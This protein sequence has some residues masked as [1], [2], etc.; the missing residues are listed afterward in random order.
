MI[1]APGRVDTVQ[2]TEKTDKGRALARPRKG[3]FS[4][5][6]AK[7]QTDDPLRGLGELGVD[8]LEQGLGIPTIGAELVQGEGQPAGGGL[9]VLADGKGGA[10]RGASGGVLSHRRP[11]DGDRLADG[12]AAQC[13]PQAERTAAQG[14]QETGGQSAR[15]GDPHG[16]SAQGQQSDT[17]AADGQQAGGKTANGQKT[18]GHVAD[19]NDSLGPAEPTIPQVD[20][21]QRQAEEGAAAAELIAPACIVVLDDSLLRGRGCGLFGLD[22]PHQIVQ[23]DDKI[24][25]QGGQVAEIRGGGPGFP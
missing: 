11:A 25:G 9:G 13:Q 12:A 10:E 21:H 19:G 3:S 17:Q 7:K 4:G 2:L 16:Q 23:T 20:M 1:G 18:G 14:K 24:V 22:S 15:G 6:N 8:H 5:A